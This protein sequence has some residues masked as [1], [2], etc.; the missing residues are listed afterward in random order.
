M[1]WGLARVFCF[2][3]AQDTLDAKGPMFWR[4]ACSL[5]QNP[6]WAQL[7]AQ[8]ANGGNNQHRQF[9]AGEM[10]RMAQERQFQQ[11]FSQ[12]SNWSANLQQQTFNERWASDERRQA[13][14][15]EILGGYTNYQDPNS[16]YGNVH[17]DY[18][19]SRYVW[20]DGQGNWQESEDPNFDPNIGADRYWYRAQRR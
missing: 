1:N 18:S 4:I 20:T 10:E 6:Q 17:Q 11:Q 3:A 7:F 16:V 12:Y 15:G 5:R 13:G 14:M 8:V 2:R 19:N 9:V